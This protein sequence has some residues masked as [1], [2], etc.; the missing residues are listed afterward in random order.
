MYAFHQ[1]MI[2]VWNVN[3]ACFLSFHYLQLRMLLYFGIIYW[4]WEESLLPLIHHLLSPFL[5]ALTSV[6]YLNIS[7]YLSSISV[8]LSMHL[9]I[10]IVW[11]Y[12][13][14]D[15]NKLLLTPNREPTTH[16]A[17]PTCWTDE[18]SWSYLWEYR[19][20][21]RSTND[22]KTAGSPTPPTP[23][24]MD[25]QLMKAG[26]LECPAQP[27]GRSVG[28]RLESVFS[29]KL[30]WSELL[31]DSSLDLCLFQAAGLRV[32]FCSP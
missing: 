9:S 23:A 1:R 2:L 14:R 4:K 6:I 19:V 25:W 13:W 17:N 5:S 28:Y 29:R 30:I 27:A 26:N 15:I 8:Y 31:P 32:P 22:P 11:S 7:I 3:Q 18:F 12:S 21:Y 20:T 24:S 16:H 10:S